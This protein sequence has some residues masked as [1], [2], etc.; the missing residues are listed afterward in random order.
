MTNTTF[1]IFL[2]IFF[3]GQKIAIFNLRNL[4][5]NEFLA[6]ISFFISIALNENEEKKFKI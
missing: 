2:N 1:G 4:V 6:K 5:K 3:S